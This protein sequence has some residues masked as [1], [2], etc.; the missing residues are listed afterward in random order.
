VEELSR[1]DDVIT[2]TRF[3]ESGMLT[4]VLIVDDDPSVRSMLK[5]VLKYKGYRV[6]TAT[7]GGDA[8]MQMSVE[9]PDIILLDLM[10]PGLDGWGFMKVLKDHCAAKGMPVPRVVVMSAH[11]RM[12]PELLL[13]S[14][15]DVLLTKPF[16][17]EE[18]YAV[19]QH[20]P[21]PVA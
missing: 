14:G 19:L 11:P 6:T 7:D 15:V 1:I 5:A 4:R 3:T 21:A 17:T 12:Q 16:D 10:M 8:L 13:K 9:C 18:L 20:L 2:S